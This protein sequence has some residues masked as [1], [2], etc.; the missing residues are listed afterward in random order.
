[1][2][3]QL[4]LPLFLGTRPSERRGTHDS[5]GAPLSREVGP[6]AVDHMTAPEP[7]RAERRGP[8]SCDTW[9]LRSPPEQRGGV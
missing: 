8:E 9:Q 1:M 2:P 6:G 7:S 4:S 5:V 3:L